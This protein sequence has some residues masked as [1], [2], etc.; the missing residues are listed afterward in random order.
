MNKDNFN[1][2]Q[3]YRKEKEFSY[4]D[5]DIYDNVF[6]KAIFQSFQ[7][8]A[9]EH[10]NILHIGYQEF[11]DRNLIWVLV[12]NSYTL[13][14]RLYDYKKYVVETIPCSEIGFNFK[15]DYRI[16]EEDTNKLVCVGTSIWAIVDLNLRKLVRIKSLNLENVFDYL[17]NYE[18]IETLRA[19]PKTLNVDL[20]K[21]DLVVKVLYTYLDHN[22]HMNNTYYSSLVSSILPL[23]ETNIIQ[24]MQINFEKEC[25]IH[26]K[27]YLFKEYKVDE[28]CYYIVGYK[29]GRDEISFTLK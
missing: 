6:S 10:A 14:S 29:N 13:L 1:D 22:R 8:V 11:K 23:D 26:D 20:D 9:G 4:S 5:V 27:I 19:L 18:E 15:R 21:P 17:P 7:D 24:H 12:R 28:E 2:K 16:Y 25:S 3:L